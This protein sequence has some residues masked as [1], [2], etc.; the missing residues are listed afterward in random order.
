MDPK[1]SIRMRCT[2][3]CVRTMSAKMKAS[4]SCQPQQRKQLKMWNHLSKQFRSSQLNQSVERHWLTSDNTSGGKDIG[5]LEVQECPRGRHKIVIG[6]VRKFWF[7]WAKINILYKIIILFI[8]ETFARMNIELSGV[9]WLNLGIWV[10]FKNLNNNPNKNVFQSNSSYWWSSC[11][12]KTTVTQL[13]KLKK[14]L[15]LFHFD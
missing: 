6:K 11:W 13:I 8:Y 10:K 7:D 4:V 3:S 2:K 14:K 12:V 9:I 15:D 1:M 5:C